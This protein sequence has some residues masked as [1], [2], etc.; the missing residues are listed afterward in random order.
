MFPLKDFYL[1]IGKNYIRRHI[2]NER[3][4]VDQKNISQFCCHQYDP[5]SNTGTLLKFTLLTRISRKRHIPLYSRKT[6]IFIKRYDASQPSSEKA[7]L[8]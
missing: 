5:N 3:L 2:T 8:I 4:A 6:I 1:V 7:R